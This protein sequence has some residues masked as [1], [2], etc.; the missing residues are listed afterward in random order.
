MQ[1]SSEMDTSV[2]VYPSSQPSGQARATEPCQLSDGEFPDDLPAGYD[3][4]LQPASQF[5]SRRSRHLAAVILAIL[6]LVA[7]IF[8]VHKI[9][10][11]QRAFLSLPH[12]ALR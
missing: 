5:R 4:M 12:S 2:G 6:F 9:S 7:S 8:L 1:V 10:N 11:P 3:W